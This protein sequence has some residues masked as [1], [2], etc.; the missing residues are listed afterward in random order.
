MICFL[1]KKNKDSAKRAEGWVPRPSAERREFL[2]AKENIFQGKCC[3]NWVFILHHLFRN[4]K[5]HFEL[6]EK[7]KREKQVI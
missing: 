5:K 1:E 7:I 3:R 6:I 4:P 2:M